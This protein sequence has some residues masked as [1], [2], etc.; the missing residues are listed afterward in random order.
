MKRKDPLKYYGDKASKKREILNES[1]KK[2]L[3]ITGSINNDRLNDILDK[4]NQ[5]VQLDRGF[6]IREKMQVIIIDSEKKLP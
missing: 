2:L 4:T 1:T 6:L 3:K 5:R